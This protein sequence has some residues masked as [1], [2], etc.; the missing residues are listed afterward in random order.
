MNTLRLLSLIECSLSC[1]SSSLGQ[2]S[3]QAETCSSTGS[4]SV[5]GIGEEF[6][7][8]I[9]DPK[10]GKKLASVGT[11]VTKKVI[12]QLKKAEIKKVHLTVADQTLVGRGKPE[13]SWGRGLSSPRSS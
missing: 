11:R 8:E 4:F 7:E 5:S 1:R 10:A 12:D 6:I 2:R 9:I 13:S 3:G